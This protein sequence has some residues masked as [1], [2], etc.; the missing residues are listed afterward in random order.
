MQTLLFSGNTRF[1]L[2]AMMAIVI[3]VSMCV[4]MDETQLVVSKESC[5]PKLPLLFCNQ[6]RSGFGPF[7]WDLKEA[8]VRKPQRDLYHLRNPFLPF[9]LGQRREA[10][11][12]QNDQQITMPYY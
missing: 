3:G 7:S 11:M 10:Q 12:G 1:L 8:E 9:R 5:N 4:P 2:V 6:K